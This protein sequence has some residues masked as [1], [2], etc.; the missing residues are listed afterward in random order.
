[1]DAQTAASEIDRVLDE[2]LCQS[3]PGYIGIPTNISSYTSISSSSLQIPRK[4]ALPRNDNRVEK[5]AVAEIRELIE[6]RSKSVII[7]DG[8][9]TR[10][11]VISEVETLCKVT[12]F[13]HI[14]NPWCKGAVSE[15]SDRFGSKPD[16]REAVESSD[17]VLWIGK[18]S[19]DFNTAEF[20]EYIK[21]D[22]H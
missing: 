12:N 2:M 21:L 8:G 19:G 5:R 6:K 9:A 15:A 4:T 14:S 16:I 1:M 11:N 22:S 13:P 10:S 17:C 18:L 7:V 20:I 3:P